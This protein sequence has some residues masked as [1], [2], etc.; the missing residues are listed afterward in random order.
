MF[1]HW[2]DLLGNAVEAGKVLPYELADTT[3]H[4]CLYQFIVSLSQ[5]MSYLLCFPPAVCSVCSA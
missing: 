4:C 2:D 3:A 1:D 5:H